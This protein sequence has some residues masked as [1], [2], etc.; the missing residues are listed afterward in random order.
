MPQMTA[1]MYGRAF[2]LERQFILQEKA[3][4]LLQNE[5]SLGR[6]KALPPI[7]ESV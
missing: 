2:G 5:L 4:F 7:P 3:C 6:R 1:G